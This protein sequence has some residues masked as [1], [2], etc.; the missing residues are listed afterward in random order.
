LEGFAEWAER[1]EV[2]TEGDMAWL[3][4]P[5]GRGAVKVYGHGMVVIH[6]DPTGSTAWFADLVASP[7][8]PLVV[9][10]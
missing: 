8:G 5:A 2:F 10:R 6:P 7:P 1:A 3:F 9:A 4:D